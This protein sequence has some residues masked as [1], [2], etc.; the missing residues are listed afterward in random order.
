MTGY[1]Y[2]PSDMRIKS[3]I[4]QVD[5]K[6]QLRRIR[7][8]KIYDYQVHSNSERGGILS[9]LSLAPLLS[10]PISSSNFFSRNLVLAQEL[11]TVMP[12]AVHTMG[13]TQIGGT[14]IPNFL[15]VNERTLLYESIFLLFY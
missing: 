8:L 10:F 4:T 9:F 1:L 14:T 12:E 13:D 11:A 15:V 7:K 5:N 6:A 2:K 3:E